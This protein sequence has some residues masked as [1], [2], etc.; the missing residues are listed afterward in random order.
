MLRLGSGLA[1]PSLEG[2]VGAAGLLCPRWFWC[3]ILMLSRHPRGQAG[4]GFS[5]LW[6]GA[7]HRS[8]QCREAE[9]ASESSRPDW[10]II[11]RVRYKRKTQGSS[12]KMT[13]TY[14]AEQETKFGSFYVWALCVP[15]VLATK[16]TLP[17]SARLLIFVSGETVLHWPNPSFHQN[18]IK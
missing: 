13:E 5:L 10:G 14:R 8:C 17:R 12:W 18:A 1:A 16:L 15:R 9:A 3:T 4:F 7:F 6:A 11:C 2:S